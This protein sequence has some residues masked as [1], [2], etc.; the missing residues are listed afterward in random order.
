M[1]LTDM[2]NTSN[3]IE[4]NI[5]TMSTFGVDQDK[6]LICKGNSDENYSSK[7]DNSHSPTLS[8]CDSKGTPNDNR[9]SKKSKMKKKRK[10]D[11]RNS[12]I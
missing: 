6:Q 2:F 11:G 8:M 1:R 12:L 4:E 10:I 5:K 3:D 9:S 7:K